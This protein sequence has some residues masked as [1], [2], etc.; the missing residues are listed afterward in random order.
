M[1]KTRR[2]QILIQRTGPL[3]ELRAS[4]ETGTPP[5]RYAISGV[6]WAEKVEALRSLPLYSTDHIDTI[7]DRLQA[8]DKIEVHSDYTDEALLRIGFRPAP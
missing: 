8:T 6:T 7:A 2:F 5:V 3:V 4:S 1:P